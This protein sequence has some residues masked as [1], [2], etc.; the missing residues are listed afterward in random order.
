MLRILA[1]HFD[2]PRVYK[3]LHETLASM[4]FVHRWLDGEMV[5]LHRSSVRVKTLE[6]LDEAIEALKGFDLV[7]RPLNITDADRERLINDL[8]FPLLGAEGAI[9]IMVSILCEEYG[10]SPAE[11]YE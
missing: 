3:Q 4:V 8:F 2:C 7:N 1:K 11:V 10:I 5:D 6:E 9:E